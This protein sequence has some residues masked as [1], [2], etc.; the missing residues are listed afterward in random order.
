MV[1]LYV[2]KIKS[3]AINPE[4]GE[5]WTIDDVPVRWREAVREELEK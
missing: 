1:K 5:A 3:G 4:T 2:K